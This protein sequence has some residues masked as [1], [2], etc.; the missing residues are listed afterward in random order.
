MVVVF[1]VVAVVIVV[2]VVVVVVV[3]EVIVGPVVESV[4]DLIF[5]SCQSSI[6]TLQDEEELVGVSKLLLPSHML[7]VAH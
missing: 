3:V 5:A 1:V 4:S 6:V 2:V 7:Y